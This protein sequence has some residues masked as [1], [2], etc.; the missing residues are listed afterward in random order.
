MR[1]YLVQVCTTS[2]FL[3][4]RWF[5]VKRVIRGCSN[6]YLRYSCHEITAWCSVRIL[7][8]VQ[9]EDV[10]RQHN[11]R[12]FL[13]QVERSLESLFIQVGM[14]WMPYDDSFRATIALNNFYIKS[15][16]LLQEDGEKLAQFR[17]FASLRKPGYRKR[18]LTRYQKR[19]RL[20]VN[21]QFRCSQFA[22]PQC[23]LSYARTRH[24]STS[25]SLIMSS[26]YMTSLK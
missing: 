10:K 5:F 11:C 9:S 20:C 6:S 25:C 8:N 12:K 23:G 2:I 4:I 7:L 15:H 3:T 13:Q 1:R 19:H 21:Q 26:C 14:E 16:P 24:C 17:K 22:V 18:V